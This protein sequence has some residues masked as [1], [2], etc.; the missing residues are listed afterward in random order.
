M[1]EGTGRHGSARDGRRRRRESCRTAGWCRGEIGRDLVAVLDP[2][3]GA[4]TCAV[5]T[6]LARVLGSGLKTGSRPQSG[7][8]LPGLTVFQTSP[9][10]LPPSPISPAHS[11][12]AH[13]A[14]R[15]HSSWLRPPTLAILTSCTRTRPNTRP[16]QPTTPATR[17]ATS[18]PPSASRHGL[19]PSMYHTHPTITQP[20]SSPAA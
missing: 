18:P 6:G 9:P 1:E 11:S 14:T 4:I 10:P 5:R 17:T 19:Q 3:N 20:L 13:S 8:G 7:P 2:R 16:R 15:E 12:N